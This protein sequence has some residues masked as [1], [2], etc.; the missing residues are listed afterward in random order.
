MKQKKEFN[1]RD[2]FKSAT[3]A[4]AGLAIAPSVLMG[5]SS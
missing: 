5:A 4:G 1:R 2:F 3:L